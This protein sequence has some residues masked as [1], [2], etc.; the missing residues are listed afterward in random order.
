MPGDQLLADRG[1]TLKED[2]A[3]VCSAE[4]IIPAFTKGKT[5]L[6]AAEVEKSRQLAS[7]RIHIERVIGV[8]RNRYAILRSTLQI[9]MIKSV[10]EE[11][12][13]GS[14]KIDRLLRTCAVLVN[15]GESIVSKKQ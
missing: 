8:M 4:L 7:V 14:V 2:F 6:S 3:T 12:G 13:A 9:P 11:D 1:F 10:L 5:Q 15:L